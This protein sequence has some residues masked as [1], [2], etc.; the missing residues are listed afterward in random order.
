MLSYS[1]HTC[2]VRDMAQPRE[3]GSEGGGEATTGASAPGTASVSC[4]LVLFLLVLLF[5]ALGERSLARSRD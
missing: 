1:A 4:L 3:D 5:P 2:R